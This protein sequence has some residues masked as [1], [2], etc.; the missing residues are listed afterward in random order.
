MREPSYSRRTDLEVHATLFPARAR[1]VPRSFGAGGVYEM[2]D[3]VDAMN[4]VAIVIGTAAHTLRSARQPTSR[5]PSVLAFFASLREPSYSRRTDPEVHVT[6]F[7]A[8]ARYVPRSFGAGGVFE[9]T[10]V[11]DAM[12]VV[13]IVIGTAA[14]TLRARG[15]PSH[16]RQE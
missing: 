13:A 2:T 4:V 14:H 6:L 15:S 9:M 3:V 10:D 1:Y 8:R 12:N 16:A 5:S 11:V 7:P